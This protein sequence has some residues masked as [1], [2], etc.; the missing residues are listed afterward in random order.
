VSTITI[1]LPDDE[2]L[3][4]EMR[5]SAAIL[6]YRLGLISQGRGAEIAGMDRRGFIQALGRAGVDAIQVDPEELKAE[7]E[8]ELEARRQRLADHLPPS[9]GPA[10]PVE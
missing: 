9:R 10:G 3:A 8:R 4:L 5:L 6:W 7:V 2:D 1:E